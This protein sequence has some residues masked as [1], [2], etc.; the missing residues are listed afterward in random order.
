MISETIITIQN[1][2]YQSFMYTDAQNIYFLSI[3]ELSMNGIT[4]NRK[5]KTICERRVMFIEIVLYVECCIL[6]QYIYEKMPK[7]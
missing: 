5:I 2:N 7:K 3:H 6:L 1:T 4:T